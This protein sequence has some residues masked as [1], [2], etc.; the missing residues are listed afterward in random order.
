MDQLRAKVGMPGWTLQT[1]V[2]EFERMLLIEA[3]KRTD[4]VKTRA[5][6]LLGIHES[7]LRKKMKELRIERYQKPV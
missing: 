2:H 3:L 7:T 6:N 4:W 1:A 5:A